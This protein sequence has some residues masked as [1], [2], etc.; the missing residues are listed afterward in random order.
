MKKMFSILLC[1]ILVFSSAGC[2]EKQPNQSNQPEQKAQNEEQAVIWGADLTDG[3]GGRMFEKETLG[4]PDANVIL[5]QAVKT[6]DNIYLFGKG[7]GNEAYLYQLD[8][9]EKAVRRIADWDDNPVGICEYPEGKIS[10]LTMD[11][12]GKYQLSQLDG[13][14]SVGNIVFPQLDIYESD[15]ITQITTVKNGFVVVT[16]TKVLALDPAGNL[17]KEL[18]DYNASAA[19][20]HQT[21]GNFFVAM[22]KSDASNLN[23]MGTEILLIDENFNVANTYRFQESYTCFF[24]DALAPGNT[25]LAQAGNILFRLDIEKNVREG[26]IDTFASGMRPVD[27]ICL[28]EDLLFSINDGK[29]V[30]W[31]PANTDGLTVITLAAYK[32]DPV[33][34]EFV[35]R[36]NEGGHQYRINVVDYS[37]YDK[38]DNDN[39]GLT[40]LTTDIVS[41]NTPDI[42]DLANLPAEKYAKNGL[43][44][45]LAPY[46]TEGG[47]L[48]REDLIPSALQALELNGKLFFMTPAF[49]ILTLCGDKSV[50]GDTGSWTPS[51]FFT[52]A[53]S[54]DAESLFGPEMT[55]YD[56]LTYV[57]LF[58]GDEYVDK[59]TGKCQFDNPSF[60]QFVSLAATFPAEYD[61]DDPNRPASQSWSR[62]FTGHQAL[63]LEEYGNYAISW[64]AFADTIYGGEAQYVGFPTNSGTGVALDPTFLISMS[65]SSS[66]KD[67]V[68]DFI[69]F[70]LD[71]N[72]QSDT[73][74]T[75]DCPIVQKFLDERIDNWVKAYSDNPPVL[76]TVFDDAP[77]DIPGVTSPE[78]AKERFYEMLNKID[79][80]A[81]LDD[82]LFGLIIKECESFFSGG[83]SVDQVCSNIQSKAQIYM[84]EQYG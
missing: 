55:R 78:T 42:Y 44:E 29:P 57:M 74:L 32:L 13:N 12:D 1:L 34:S 46:F 69:S 50:V 49:R 43:F 27:L 72:C 65:A 40:R 58:L 35:K 63:L 5:R 22:A 3:G 41:G 48:H 24:E 68:I 45:D 8:I 7:S 15:F 14:E 20:I 83:I 28:D 71:N 6:T 21:Q 4:L 59:D 54:L 53:S 64:M 18:G 33:L 60:K 26:L 37:V 23:N 9:N 76:H 25:I 56:F 67:G 84:S 36:Y 70:M 66:K 11:E 47:I 80:L 51:D 38:N 82:D 2:A 39:I 61:P 77:V 52:L 79:C 62:A 17:V 31:R 73:T 30:L 81:Y 75:P 16:T 19:C 10:V